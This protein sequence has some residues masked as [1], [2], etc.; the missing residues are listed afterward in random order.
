MKKITFTTIALII[1][2]ISNAQ[3]AKTNFSRSLTGINVIV[4]TLSGNTSVQGS[5]GDDLRVNSFLQTKGDIWGWKFPEKRPEFKIEPVISRDTLYI[6][7]PAVY[8]PATIGV[9]TYSEHIENVIQI[10]TGKKLIV[11]QAKKLSV[12]DD[13]KYL[14][15]LNADNLSVVIHKS[16]IMRLKC[17]A[18]KSVKINSGE[19]SKTYLLEGTG[20]DY[21]ALKANQ[22]FV[23]FK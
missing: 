20:A 17:E 19:V 10:P 6:T 7:T 14:S 15:I 23:N 16:K 3:V 11:R 22:I 1:G 8:T 18:F 21:Y 12:E 9:S 4:L 2:F 13:F 5:V